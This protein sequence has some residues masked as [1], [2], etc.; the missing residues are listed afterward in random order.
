MTHSF[1]YSLFLFEIDLH[2]ETGDFLFDLNG[3]SPVFLKTDLF[4]VL[5]CPGL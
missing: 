2:K 5:A 4:I 3:K 1:S